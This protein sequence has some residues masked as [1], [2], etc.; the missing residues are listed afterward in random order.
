MTVEV[1]LWL[2]IG[3]LAS[4]LALSLVE[5]GKLHRRLMRAWV[6]TDELRERLRAER[7]MLIVTRDALLRKIHVISERSGE[8]EELAHALA[9]LAPL[10][11]LRDSTSEFGRLKEE[12]EA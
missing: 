6:R 2:A 1:G 10:R 12:A 11:E 9:Q 3:I 4:M 7:H 5:L 8:I